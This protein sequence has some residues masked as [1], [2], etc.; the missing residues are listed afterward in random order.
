MS[1]NK[2]ILVIFTGGTIGMVATAHGYAPQGGAFHNLLNQIPELHAEGMPNWD[3][4]DMDPLLDS[5]NITVL[6]WNKIGQVIADHYASYDGFVVLHG[7]DTMAY[8]ASALSFMLRSNAK[9][10]ILTGSQIPL[11]EVRNDAR[12][13]IITSLLIAASGQV[14][15]V[16]LYFGGR[17]LRGNRAIKYSADD[18]IAF[19]SPNYPALAEAGIAIRYNHSALLPPSQG[20]FSLQIL[21][22]VPIGVIKVFPGIQFELFDSIMTERLKG[23][24]IE[25]FGAGNIP[26]HADSLLPIIRKASDNGTVIIVCSQCPH[27][28]VSLG[29]Y[30][31]SS[32]LKE[33]GAVSGYDITTEAAVAKLYYLFSRGLNRDEICVRMERSMRGEI[34]K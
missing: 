24:V 21:T 31:T 32:A 30:E 25:T 12:D 26:G 28:T 13:N 4:I 10:V 19:E 5:S 6:E 34:T 8:T 22:N 15:E 23:I 16:C 18:L 3:I 27:G 1:A 2:R 9:P 33:A 11:C 20:S 17:L 29:T 14:H 7:T